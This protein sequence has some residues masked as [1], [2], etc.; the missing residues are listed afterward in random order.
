M[1]VLMGQVDSE[2]NSDGYLTALLRNITFISEKNLGLDQYLGSLF[3]ADVAKL[4]QTLDGHAKVGLFNVL[5]ALAQKDSNRQVL[6]NYDLLSYV[7]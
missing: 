7:R 2:R 1:H 6:G 5:T 3:M 4:I